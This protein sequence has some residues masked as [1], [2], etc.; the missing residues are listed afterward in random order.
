MSGTGKWSLEADGAS[1]RLVVVTTFAGKFIDELDQCLQLA[2]ALGSQS[3]QLCCDRGTR[4]SP[5]RT[6]SL[7]GLTPLLYMS[8]S[9]ATILIDQLLEFAMEGPAGGVSS[10]GGFVTLVYRR[11]ALPRRPR[12]FL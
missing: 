8:S 5:S 12:F 11:A 3:P 1:G 4:F 10:I 7:V 9:R 6:G 2:I